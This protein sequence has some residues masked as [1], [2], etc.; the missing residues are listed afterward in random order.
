MSPTSTRQRF[1]Y[2]PS[3]R[4][5]GPAVVRHTSLR[6]NRYTLAITRSVAASIRITAPARSYVPSTR[7]PVGA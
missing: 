3:A 5:D 6:S 4:R 7:I 1:A 2:N